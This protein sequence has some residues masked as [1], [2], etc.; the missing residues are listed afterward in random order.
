MSTSPAGIKHERIRHSIP[1]RELERRWTAIRAA[2]KAAGIGCLVLQNDNQYLGGYCRYFTDIP[3]EQAYPWTVLFPVDEGMTLITHGGPLPSPPGPFEF[4]VRGVR[5]RISLPYLRTLHYTNSWDAAAAVEQ[6]KRRGDKKVGL[7][8]LGAMHAAFYKYLTENLPGVEF[9]EF[10][11]AVDQIKAVKSE[12]DLIFIRKTVETHDIVFA[13]MPAIIRPGM[14]EYQVRGEIARI[15]TDLGSEEQLIMMSSAPAGQRAMN[16]HSFWQNRQIQW[17]DQVMI[18]I[19]PNGPGGFYGEI[20]RTWCLGD[21]PQELLKLWNIAVEAQRLTARLSVPGARPGDIFNAVNQFLAGHGLPLEN[22]LF[23]HGQGYDLVE[24]PAY[25]V[26]ETMTLQ[27]N[28]FVALHPTA[29]TDTAFAWCCDN[30]LI[31]AQGAVRLHKTP[32][33]IFVINC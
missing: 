28:M 15:L 27:P 23:S 12:D 10:T 2:M 16:I 14:Y 31:T 8:G 24:R 6:L 17:G 7:V 13:A 32:Q 3:T 22:R 20:G 4:A 29:M 25:R 18:M 21:A 11:E 30:F 9:V 19:E 5:H 26:E 33:E 1:T